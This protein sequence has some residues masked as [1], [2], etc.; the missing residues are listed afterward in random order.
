MSRLLYG[1]IVLQEGR[2]LL[3]YIIL[4]LISLS[5]PAQAAAPTDE[6]AVEAGKAG[7]NQ[8][9]D[10]PWYDAQ[11][12]S[13]QPIEIPPPAPPP[14]PPSAN[15]DLSWVGVFLMYA[16][17]TL[18]A[19]LVALIIFLMLRADWNQTN[20][21]A[22]KDEQ[23]P[24]RPIDLD[25]VEELPF[26][27]ANQKQDYFTSAE[28][29]YRAGDYST[30]ILYLYSH[31]LLELDRAQIIHLSRGK[32]NRQ[33]LRETRRASGAGPVLEP[34][35]IAFE[36]V[37]FGHHPLSRERFEACWNEIPRFKS[38]LQQASFQAGLVPA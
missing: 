9:W 22:F 20:S 18:L 32:T 33:Y 7:L 6:E 2:W 37:F 27:L 13:A 24:D 16:A 38:L 26:K 11:T 8:F 30:A 19:L 25:R 35:M 1:I 28:E 10:Y 36:D 4:C 14:S 17:W 12:D 31:Q 21:L 34:T 29:Y 15:W 23:Q 3:G 5:L